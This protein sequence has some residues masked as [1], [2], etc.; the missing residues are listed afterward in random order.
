MSKTKT[1]LTY[2]KGGA[3][4]PKEQYRELDAPTMQIA[5]TEWNG[6]VDL[7]SAHEDRIDNWSVLFGGDEIEASDAAWVSSANG[8]I[9][10]L[11]FKNRP[12]NGHRYALTYLYHWGTGTDFMVS[13]VD[14]NESTEVETAI[15]TE[16]RFQGDV[17][18]DL[19]DGNGNVIGKIMAATADY[20]S[21]VAP[22]GAATKRMPYCLDAC[23]RYNQDKIVDIRMAGLDSDN[24]AVRAEIS[25]LKE[26]LTPTLLETAGTEASDIAKCAAANVEVKALWLSQ[27][28]SSG[29][30]YVLSYLYLQT[31]DSM[32]FYNIVD[33]NVSAGTTTAVVTNGRATD[34]EVNDIVNGG[35]VIGQIMLDKT[36]Y[37][38]IADQGEGAARLPYLT[39]AC[40]DQMGQSVLME[41]EVE[42]VGAIT[43]RTSAKVAEVEE[44]L[45]PTLFATAGTEAS[46]IVKCA[47]AN[48]EVRALYLSVKPAEGHRHVLTSLYL[49]T[50]DNTWYYNIVDLNVSSGVTSAVVTHCMAEDKVMAVA[51]TPSGEAIGYVYF[52]SD[53]Y[54]LI[55]DQ[56]EGEA[57]LPYLTEACYDL[58]GQTDLFRLAMTERVDALEKAAKKKVVTLWGDSITWGSAS[59]TNSKCYAAVLQTL[60]QTEGYLHKV[61][62]CGVGGD[63]M[64]TILGRMGATMLYLGKDVTIPKSNTSYVTVD[65]VSN[66]VQVGK[67]L[68]AACKPTEQIQLMLQGDLGRSHIDDPEKDGLHTVNPVMVNGVEC[69][70]TWVPVAEGRVDEGEFRLNVNE[71]QSEPITV[72]AGTPLY[73][74]GTSLNGDVVVLAI[75]TNGGFADV[76]DYVRQMELAVESIGHGRVVICTPYGGTAL[77][78]LGGVS[79]IVELEDAVRARFGAKVFCWRKFLVEEGLDMEGL[80]ATSADTAAIAQGLVPP[81]LLADE[82]HPNDYG[83]DAIGRR[84]M[85]IV[86]T[87]GWI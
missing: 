70:W 79:G 6:V 32:W 55:A 44:E 73:P 1:L 54:T 10:A 20:S 27:K 8:C 5:H 3:R 34:G 4:Y 60:L 76:A 29:H 58:T 81:S 87:M 57:R 49:Q 14:L 25:A 74:H 35:Q 9:K 12:A 45:F 86:K 80:T 63:N 37:T 7:L 16:F 67:W 48:E 26:T 84:L 41:N 56:G 43:R 52:D 68:K 72:H 46:D 40:F 2:L 53:H 75:G 77:S 22:G 83:H 85:D 50:S 18:T 82:V 47:A 11:Y 17:L 38:L 13:L 42:T 19:T 39:D 30:R 66:Y 28:P 23:F 33:L 69:T 61:V 65:T 71:T 51:K 62:N 31:T 15:V 59:T 36:H 24:E 78:I 21:V 64:P